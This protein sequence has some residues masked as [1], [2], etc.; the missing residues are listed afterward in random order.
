MDAL[1]E[2]LSTVNI[3]RNICYS[4]ALSAPW[5]VCSEEF[6]GTSFWTVRRGSCWL[7]TVGLEKPL[8]LVAGDFILFPRFQEYTLYDTPESLASKNTA[9]LNCD[10]YLPSETI[11]LPGKGLETTLLYGKL[12]LEGPIINQ[13]LTPL[14][15]FVLIREEEAQATPWLNTTIQFLTAEISSQNPG[16]SSIINH[17]LLVLF[18]QTIRHYIH[19]KGEC[20]PEK[21]ERCWLKALKDS[22]IGT[23]I[24]LIHRYPQKPWTVANLATEVKMSRSGFASTFRELVGE[25]P[26]QYLT[27]WRMQKAAG[28]LRL[29]YQTVSEVASEV[30]YESEAAFSNAFKRWMQISPG[31]F[32]RE[33]QGKFQ[34][35]IKNLTSDF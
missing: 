19:S 17:L 12:E 27:R 5:G 26:L 25:P 24:T 8:S 22:Q 6:I 1:S 34:S 21:S 33:N 14:P 11:K 9:W 18:V 4:L 13:L 20:E 35:Q 23:A 28:L 15:P 30:G 7:Q 3:E 29:G 10:S 2:V 32:R 16:S 31:A